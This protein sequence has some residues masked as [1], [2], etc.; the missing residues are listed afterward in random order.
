M[1][2]K[3][4][5]FT[6][7]LLTNINEWHTY[8]VDTAPNQAHYECDVFCNAVNWSHLRNKF[9]KIQLC[10]VGQYASAYGKCF[11]WRF[12]RSWYLLIGA[13]HHCHL[14]A[15]AILRLSAATFFLGGEVFGYARVLWYSLMWRMTL[16]WSKN[17]RSLRRLSRNDTPRWGGVCS[18]LATA[19]IS[20][21]NQKETSQS[22]DASSGPTISNH[23]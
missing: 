15:T 4:I 16:S 7:I 23:P 11:S 9:E 10:I 6:K 14:L 12:N 2:D 5:W 20:W 18:V 22:I 17:E 1:S 8:D 13:I 19:P 21:S 3:I